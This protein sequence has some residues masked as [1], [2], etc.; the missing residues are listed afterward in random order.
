MTETLNPQ[1]CLIYV[2]VLVSAADREMTDS[3]LYTIGEIVRTLPIFED[4]DQNQLVN[5]SQ[6]CA[7]ILNSAEG[8][9]TVLELVNRSLPERLH[10]TAYALACDVAAADRN[11]E[12][13]EIQVLEM[14][15]HRL[16]IDRLNAA[17]IERGARARYSTF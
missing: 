7:E 6:A 1:S 14:I 11:V 5:V 4:F 15:R 10:E 3:E 17:A 2:M 16:H 13:E 8:L 9:E 12:Q